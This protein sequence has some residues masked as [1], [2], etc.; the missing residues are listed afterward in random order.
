MRR[1]A[2]SMRRQSER[3]APDPMLGMT[4]LSR[5]A[6]Q[7]AWP[8]SSTPQLQA[9]RRRFAQAASPVWPRTRMLK[10][11]ELKTRS[12]PQFWQT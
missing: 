3:F 5:Q 8:G 12:R 11:P 4:R 7:N 9:E 10:A 1:L 2:S 6:T